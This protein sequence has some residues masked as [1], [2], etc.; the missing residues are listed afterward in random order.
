MNYS[1]FMGFSLFGVHSTRFNV[2]RILDGGRYN[3]NLSPDFYNATHSVDG[4]HGEYDFGTNI[5]SKPISLSC[6][7]ENITESQY[8][9]LR[10]WLS[11]KNRGKLILDESP[12]KAYTVGLERVANF[13]FLPVND[14]AGSFV[15]T[16]KF[17]LNLIAYDPYAYSVFDS[18]DEVE[19][20]KGYFYNSGLLY[21]SLL[22]DTTFS[23]ISDN[24]SV[25][26]YTG[27]TANSNVNV[28]INGMGDELTIKN[29]TTDQYFTL[30]KTPSLETFEVDANYGQCRLNGLLASDYHDGTYLQLA[31]T[32]RVDHY[33]SVSFTNG[34]DI[35]SF[36]IDTMLQDDIIGKYIFMQGDR[37]K[38]IDKLNDRQLKLDNAF[39]GDTGLYNIVIVDANEVIITG[40]NLNIANLEFLY[41]YT[42]I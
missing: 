9:Q 42:Y 3:D 22:P 39:R 38:I 14:G 16:G 2:Y 6:F 8:R 26:L 17:E 33:E 10:R 34:D 29:I 11:P 18:L 32:D 37:Y 35:T 30:R 28:R 20:D 41:K 15:Y 4:Y 5:K 1:P 25:I 7:G 13:S 12:Y 19:Y 24:K 27:G 21:A 40:A 36:S 31:G 23:N